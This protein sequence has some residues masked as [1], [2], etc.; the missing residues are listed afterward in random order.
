MKRTLLMLLSMAVL[1][2]FVST[3]HADKKREPKKSRVNTIL[4]QIGGDHYP[5]GMELDDL[6]AVKTTLEDETEGNYRWYYWIFVGE[7]PDDGGYHVIIFDNSP[8]PNYLGYYATSLKPA[9]TGLEFISFEVEDQG[10][11]PDP[12]TDRLDRKSIELTAKGPVARLTIPGLGDDPCEFV[13]APE[14]E[15]EETATADDSSSSSSS[16]SSTTK[17]KKIKPVYRTWHITLG[18][19]VIE[20]ESAI[21]VSYKNGLVTIKDA[22][23]G[24]TVSKPLRDFSDEDRK[25]LQELLK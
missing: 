4:K 14:P 11:A 5:E 8:E 1:I 25:Y 18:D 3:S 12:K 15:K 7:L 20:V 13:P 21:Y 6:G 17:A 2:G 10:G 23:T 22:K 16:S 24:R 9:E 19:K